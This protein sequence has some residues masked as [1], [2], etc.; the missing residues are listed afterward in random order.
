MAN[1]VRIGAQVT[2]AKQ[3]ASDLDRLRDKFDRLQKQGAKGFA[4][5]AGAAVT[6]AA[7]NVMG[8]AVSAVTDFIGDSIHAYAEEEQ[9]VSKLGASLKANI[10]AWDGNTKAI[11]AT[12]KAQ[13]ALGFSDEEQRD[14]LARLVAAT[15]DVSQAMTIQRTAMDLARFKG[16]S[17]ADATEALTK[18]E[19]GSY[20]ILKSL[21]ISLKDGATQTEALAA[22]QRVANGQADAYAKTIS[23]KLLIAQIKFNEAQEKFGKNIAPIAAD[24]M[25]L[26]GDLAT[27]VGDAY[28]RASAKVEGSQSAIDLAVQGG[29]MGWLGM[30]GAIGDVGKAIDDF[31]NG[32]AKREQ[33]ALAENATWLADSIPSA[34]AFAL[35]HDHMAVATGR[36]T[37]AIRITTKT[38]KEL[39]E[40]ARLADTAVG[41]LTAAFVDELYGD[42][43]RAGDRADLVK[44]IGD[45]KH[46]LADTKNQ[47]DATIIKGQIAGLRG[48]LLTL[49]AQIAEAAGPAAYK[50]WFD[51]MTKATDS[52]DDELRDFLAHA[53]ALADLAGKLPTVKPIWGYTGHGK[54]KG[55][56]A[57]GLTLVG[58][59]GPEIVDLPTGS[60]VH[61]S[62]QSRA[63]LA[64]GS[65]ASSVGGGTTVNLTVNVTPA[66]GMTPA[67]AR[68]IGDALG[69]ILTDYQYR[70]GIIGRA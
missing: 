65:P 35:A 44:R 28:E 30:F 40:A 66:I 41:D 55:G 6:T 34:K 61:S 31:V 16:I 46:E 60:F 23:G 58:E 54:A 5:G 13:M 8:G 51:K 11:E 33:A 42:T 25:G 38:L 43:I 57:S 2:G 47:G 29:T 3:A 18:V 14:S 32:P 17:L 52:A 21:G 56:P 12:M 45:L 64:S 62:P 7:L 10:P 63:M 15:H 68:A 69:P 36:A 48:E 27:T 49:D 53:R 39:R 9:S 50:A 37:G 4:I 1:T 26:L 24:A 59:E 19:A 22:V 20:R 70:R 67:T